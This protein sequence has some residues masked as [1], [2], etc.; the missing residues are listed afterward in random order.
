MTARHLAWAR[1]KRAAENESR[2]SGSGCNAILESQRPEL[3]VQ[4]AEVLWL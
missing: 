4:E 1:G 3:N 2:L